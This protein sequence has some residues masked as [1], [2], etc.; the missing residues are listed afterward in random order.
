MV[1][2]AGK[3]GGGR[4]P[5]LAKNTGSS[6]FCISFFF[7]FFFFLSFFITSCRCICLIVLLLSFPLRDITCQVIIISCTRLYTFEKIF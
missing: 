5:A 2:G 4:V 3:G 7:F 1:C 6:R